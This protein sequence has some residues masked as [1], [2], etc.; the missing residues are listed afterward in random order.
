MV[1]AKPPSLVPASQVA[2]GK[3]KLM[4][5]CRSALDISINGTPGGGMISY[6]EGSRQ[7]STSA[8]AGDASSSQSA[9]ERLAKSLQKAPSLPKHL[10]RLLTLSK[11]ASDMS[12]ATLINL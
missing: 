3:L 12:A 9:L 2:V 8:V 7:D 6:Q 4:K 1:F 11:A 5:N 10:A